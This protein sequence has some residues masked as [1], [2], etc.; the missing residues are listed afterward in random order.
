VED[1][2]IIGVE[3]PDVGFW[4]GDSS[5]SIVLLPQDFAEM[6]QV[7]IVEIITERIFNFF[8]SNEEPKE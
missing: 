8:T 7:E 5:E 1:G 4:D 2:R 3:S 6:V